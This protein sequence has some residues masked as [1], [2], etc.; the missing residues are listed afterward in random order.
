MITTAYISVVVVG[1]GGGVVG[2]GGPSGGR[3]AAVKL[4]LGLWSLPT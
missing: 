3:V 1:G 2:S 4:F